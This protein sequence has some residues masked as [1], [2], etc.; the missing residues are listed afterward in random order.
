MNI[1]AEPGQTI[2]IISEAF[3]LVHHGKLLEYGSE[4][5]LFIEYMQPGYATQKLHIPKRDIQYVLVDVRADIRWDEQ[6]NEYRGWYRD[7][8]FQV[9][10]VVKDFPYLYHG[11]IKGSDGYGNL[12][13]AADGNPELRIPREQ[14]KRLVPDTQQPGAGWENFGDM[15]GVDQNAPRS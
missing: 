12:L 11:F 9:Y 6:V 10:V 1:L 15:G 5:D 3:P 8:K 14:I 7:D 4:G 2:Y 13:L